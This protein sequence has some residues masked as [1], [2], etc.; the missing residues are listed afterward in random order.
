MYALGPF[1]LKQPHIQNALSSQLCEW[2]KMSNVE[3][4]GLNGAKL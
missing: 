1:A 4:K 2:H 3:E